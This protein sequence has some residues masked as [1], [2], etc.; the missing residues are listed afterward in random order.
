[1]FVL[2]LLVYS[3]VESEGITCSSPEDNLGFSHSVYSLTL[4]C[5]AILSSIISHFSESY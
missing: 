5:S 3:M 2:R 1:M 4:N